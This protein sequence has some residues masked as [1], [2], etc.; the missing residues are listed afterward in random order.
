MRRFILYAA[1]SLALLIPVQ[2]HAIEAGRQVLPNGLTVLHLERNNLPLVVISMLVRAGSLEEPPSKPGLS[3]LTATL[4]PEGTLTRTASDISAEA[5]FIGADLSVSAGVDYAQMNLVVLKK[6]VDKGFELFSDILLNPG[7]PQAEI[8][9]QKRMIKNSLK[10]AEDS[11]SYLASRAFSRELF[12]AN[13]YGREVEGTPESIDAMT[14]DDMVAFHSARYVPNASIMA[15]SGDI[16]QTEL[17]GLIHKYLGKWTARPVVDTEP[18]APPAKTA[19]QRK[20]VIDKSDLTQATIMLGHAGVRRDN[21]DY[22]ALAVMNYIL[23]GGGFSSRMMEIIRDKMGLAYG[24]Q[25]SFSAAWKAGD[26]HVTVQTKNASAKKVIDE[27]LGQMRIM[28]KQGV[29]E[30]ELAS[31]KS[32]LIGSFPRRFDSMQGVAGSLVAVE[33]YGLGLDYEKKYKRLISAVSREDVLRVARRYLDPENYILVVVG[34]QAITGIK[35]GDLQ[36]TPP[37]R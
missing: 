7:F 21:P 9:R 5:E 13:A 15:V 33:F 28:R 4:M 25:S 30:R 22:Y 17:N 29:T 14:R 16:T 11:P 12:G 26:F 18:S 24:V 34:S 2:A 36:S 31:A 3:N 6:D 37:V 19:G 20:I 10:A 27:I 35:A 32:Y 1:M 23:G 8:D